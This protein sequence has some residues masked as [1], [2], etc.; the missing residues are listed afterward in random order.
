MKQTTGQNKQPLWITWE[1]QIRNRN[2]SERL[3]ANLLELDVRGGKFKRYIVCTLTTL[4]W[5]WRW[6]RQVVV[7]QNPSLVLNIEAVLLR[8]VFGYTLIM[9]AH[10]AGILPA[11]GKKPVLLRIANWAIRH[12]DLVLV[13]NKGLASQVTKVGGTPFILPDPLPPVSSTKPHISETKPGSPKALFICTWAA[14]EPYLEVLKA[15][16]SVPEVQFFVTGNSK[17]REQQYGRSL[18]NNVHLTGYVPDDDYEKLLTDSDLIIDLTTRENCLVCGAYESV[19]AGKPF[20]LSN[21]DALR[22][23]FRDG[24]VYVEN[25]DAAIADGIRRLLTD[26]SFYINNVLRLKNLLEGE[27]E[28]RKQALEDYIELKTERAN[29]MF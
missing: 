23:Y 3:K 15:A 27:W 14:D 21:T 13:T 16:E 20:V 11:E 9:D 6:R 19:S 18:P 1:K 17:N 2:L 12:V 24:G 10:N 4:T 29:R 8:A 5:L 7:V 25:Y 26:Y 28:H 22:D